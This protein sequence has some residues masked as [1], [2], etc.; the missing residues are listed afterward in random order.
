MELGK[1][2]RQKEFDS[3]WSRQGPV[4]PETSKGAPAVEV[5]QGS[6]QE[7]SMGSLG[8]SELLS[9][10]PLNK[11]SPRS[12]SCGK[13]CVAGGKCCGPEFA[14][15][16]SQTLILEQFRFPWDHFSLETL[17]TLSTSQIHGFENPLVFMSLPSC[18]I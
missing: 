15:S 14:H 1:L 11:R 4:L 8:T 3:H 9:L 6:G 17:D 7:V 13:L 12:Q 16:I 5:I 18:E 2:I 10:L